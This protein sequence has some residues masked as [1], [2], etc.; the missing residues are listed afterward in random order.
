M[1]RSLARGYWGSLP[2]G[3]DAGARPLHHHGHARRVQPSNSHGA[4]A[5]P[6]KFL[7]PENALRPA[8]RLKGP[9]ARGGGG[10]RLERFKGRMNELDFA[11]AS[12]IKFKCSRDIS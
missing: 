1:W 9:H 7:G 11:L 2:A 3:P 6:L 5:D 4:S 10:S 12:W 8:S